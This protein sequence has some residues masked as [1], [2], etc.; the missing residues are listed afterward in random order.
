[1]NK[2]RLAKRKCEIAARPLQAGQ[3][4]VRVALPLFGSFIIAFLCLFGS[5]MIAR[6]VGSIFL[7]VTFAFGSWCDWNTGSMRTNC[8]VILR[9]ERPQRFRLIFSLFL[10][11]ELFI[12]IGA[13]VHALRASS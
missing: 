7:A 3:P 11:G 6:L 13:V 8:G 2:K 10:L 4:S 9:S 12:L 1:V 5:T